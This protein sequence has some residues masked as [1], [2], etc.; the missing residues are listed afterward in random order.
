MNQIVVNGNEL[1]KAKDMYMGQLGWFGD[2]LIIRTFGN[3]VSL[4][5]G[6]S[7][8]CPTLDIRPIAPN[9]NI[10]ITT[11]ELYTNTSSKYWFNSDESHKV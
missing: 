10:N 2:E 9:T 4:Q 1:I 6:D 11:Q 5:T 3:I 8:S 7:W